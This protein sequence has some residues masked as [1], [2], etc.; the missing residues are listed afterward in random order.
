[1]SAGSNSVKVQL[2]L[3]VSRAHCIRGLIKRESYSKGFEDH[4]G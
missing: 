4:M 3:K 1:M 2:M